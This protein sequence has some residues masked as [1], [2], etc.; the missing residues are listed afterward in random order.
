M[1][2]KS[3]GSDMRPENWLQAKSRFLCVTT[4]VVAAAGEEYEAEGRKKK[5][6]R[7]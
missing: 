1:M 2:A 6:K 4:V 7:S 3:Q 5:E